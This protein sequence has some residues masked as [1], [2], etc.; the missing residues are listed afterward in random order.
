[1]LRY[2]ER[3]VGEQTSA[4]VLQKRRRGYQVLLTDFMVE[5]DLT[6]AA[7]RSLKPEEVIEVTIQ[8]VNARKGLLSVF[9][10]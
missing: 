4:I 10:V 6:V 7:G 1:M 9:T 5:C 2:I 3:R 8:N